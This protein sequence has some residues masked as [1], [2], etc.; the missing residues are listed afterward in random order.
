MDTL[1]IGCDLH[2]RTSNLCIQTQDGR[3]LKELKI[4]TTK[5]AFSETLGEYPG[6]HIVFEPVSQSWWLG[7]ILEDM[8]LTV[9]LANAREVKAIAHARVKNDRID[10][11]VLCTLLRG[12]LLPESYRSSK[13]AREWKELVR[14]RTSLI[15]MRTQV[16]NKI[17]ALLGRNGI[18]APLGMIFGKK[19][20][21]WLRELSLSPVHRTHLDQ[22]L[23]LLDTYEASIDVA[24]THVE[25]RAV[26]NESAT[27]LMSIPGIS[28]VSALSIMSEL[29]T[30]GRFNDGK[31]IASY[32]GLVPSVYASGDTVRYGR[33]TKRGSKTLRTIMI[34][35]AHAQ[36]RLK[37]SVGLR[38]YF[39]RIKERK[40][41][42]TATVATARKLCV[43][44]YHILVSKTAF[45]DTRLVARMR[46]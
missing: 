34:E 26:E 16:K 38:P 39:E 21:T 11:N 18:I 8:G 17:H 1:Y 23:S 28:Y 45:D 33:L 2:K 5:E 30:I 20:R 43:I 10:A 3:V 15:G 4:A 13:G 14:F 37:K 22:Y 42:R 27:L 6:A 40:G 7:D 44:I 32:A 41:A 19:G 36:G 9:Y 35:V 29:D 12:K 31:Q 25:E 24:T 46:T